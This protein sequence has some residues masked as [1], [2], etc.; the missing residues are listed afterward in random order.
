MRLHEHIPLLWPRYDDA[1]V[2][3]LLRVEHLVAVRMEPV[4]SMRFEAFLDAIF[5]SNG[6]WLIVP[7]LRVDGVSIMVPENPPITW[8]AIYERFAGPQTDAIDAEIVPWL[9]SVAAG[10]LVND[11][12]VRFFRDEPQLIETYEHARAQRLLGAAPYPEVMRSAAGAVYALR[13][14]RAG[15][16]AL[17]GVDAA[18]AA[19][20]LSPVA[21]SIDADLSDIGSR[22]FSGV[23]TNAVDDRT[24]YACYVGP[25]EAAVTAG[26][27]VFDGAAEGDE[28]HVSLAEPMPTDVTISFD[29]EDA[30]PARRFAVTERALE[31]RCAPFSAPPVAGGSSGSIA[32]VVRDDAARFSDADLDGANALAE[33]L[34]AEG[35]D[36]CVTIAA[37]VDIA[38]TDIIHVFDLRHGASLVELLRDAEAASVPVVVTPY[39]DDRRNEAVSGSSGALLIPRVSSDTI[40]FYDF[41]EAF[42]AR[43][44]SN[45]SE[46]PWYNDASDT[47]MRRA[48]A[49]HVA[50]PAEADFLRE[51]FGYGCPT[52]VQPAVVDLT[53][54]DPR[55]GSLAGPD[56]FILMHAP[57]EP[58]CN[59]VFAALAASRLRIPLV[60][61]GPVADI[62]Y[63]RY[64]NEIA[65]PWVTQLRDADLS[66]AEIAA[67]YGRARVIADVSWSARGLHRLARGAALGAAVVAPITG[68]AQDVWGPHAQFADPGAFQSIV[69]AFDAA[70]QLPSTERA[71]LI[72]RTA[73][74]ADPFTSLVAAVSM[75]QR[76]SS[77]P[78]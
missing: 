27:S 7:M 15:H 70:W 41:V 25:R 62:E 31:L 9:R 29:L 50:A 78:A 40:A 4:Y 21:S 36:A 46:A 30:P 11:E 64:L 23:R 37:K 43:K 42:A 1:F 76:A 45:L 60:L 44:I 66:A 10:R 17:R 16:V 58:R 12:H 3:R 52:I 48:A 18:N 49:A 61:L 55:I 47:L 24:Q 22:W 75:Y 63:Y 19:A 65:G 71:E 2:E 28:R 67:L 32:L 56:D 35:F 69:A 26:Y 57:I 8:P 13:F 34:Q 38:K 72:A 6:E 33:R 14:A 53:A 5:E 20:V 51:R 39:A 77:V 74:H 73:M 54:P 68:Y 59:Q